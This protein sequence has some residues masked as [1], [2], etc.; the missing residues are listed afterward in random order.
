MKEYVCI[1]GKV[2]N[3]SQKFNGHRSQ[4]KVYLL[5]K[6]GNEDYIKTRHDNISASA[7]KYAEATAENRTH[8]K[9][10][11]QQAK[12]LSWLSTN[13]ICEN[14]GKA[15]TVYYGSGRFCSESCARS[16]TT[17]DRRTEINA[18]IS[19]SAKY[20]N[21]SR[22]ITKISKK[23]QLKQAKALKLQEYLDHDYEYL[24]YYD[25]D[26]GYN[27][28]INRAGIVISVKYLRELKHTA[29]SGDGYRRLVLSDISGKHHMVYLHRLVAYMFVPNPNNLPLINHKD[30]DPSNN[31]ADNLEWC[32]TQYNNTYNDIHLKRGKTCSETIKRNGGPWN[33]GKHYIYSDDTQH[34]LSEAAKHRGFMGN[35]YV[36]K[37]GNLHK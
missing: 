19:K 36:D 32:T 21:C 34:K 7:K 35:Q 20:R 8:I 14:C 3:S 2:C 6:Y 28:L 17:K 18:K 37:D 10:A 1:C 29:Y 4:C 23:Q 25:I 24:R 16:F 33:K 5:Q 31:C 11:K 22:N 26:F 27:Y 12:L 30:E 15:M 13:P 9:V